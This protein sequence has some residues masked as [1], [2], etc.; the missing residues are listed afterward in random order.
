MLQGELPSLDACRC[1]EVL[2]D[3]G[4]ETGCKVAADLCCSDDI[5]LLGGQRGLLRQVWVQEGGVG[6]G[7]LLRFA[8]E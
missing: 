2:E 3:G 6:D 7:S 4:K 5:R 1:V 8:E